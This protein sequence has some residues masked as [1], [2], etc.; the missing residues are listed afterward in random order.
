MTEKLISSCSYYNSDMD[1]RLDLDQM[2]NSICGLVNST[3]NAI[4]NQ[5]SNENGTNLVSANCTLIS[6]LLECLISNFTCPFM[7]DYFNGKRAGRKKE[8]R[9]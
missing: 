6:S 5:A 7:K 9:D 8:K 2:T 1:S 3:A 4:Y